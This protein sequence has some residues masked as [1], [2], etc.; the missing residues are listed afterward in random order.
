MATTVGINTAE[1]LLKLELPWAR[2]AAFL[3]EEYGITLA[4]AR[5]AVLVA[6][7]RSLATI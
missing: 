4:E 5:R 3:V 2:I 6:H 1:Q 7:Q